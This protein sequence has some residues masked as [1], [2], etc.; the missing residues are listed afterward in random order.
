[1]VLIN[2][3]INFNMDTTKIENSFIK[4][5]EFCHTKKQI[6][7]LLDILYLEFIK[8]CNEEHNLLFINWDD[9]EIDVAWGNIKDA[10]LGI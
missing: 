3:I 1:M 10:L 2:M 9:Y 4:T 5:N 7:C 8:H 6:E